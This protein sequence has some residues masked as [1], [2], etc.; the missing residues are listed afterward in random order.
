[1]CLVPAKFRQIIEITPNQSEY[2]LNN[3][4][5]IQGAPLFVKQ[6]FAL[7]FLGDLFMPNLRA[8]GTLNNIIQRC[9]AICFGYYTFL[10]K[11]YRICF[12][13]SLI[14]WC[15]VM[16]LLLYVLKFSSDRYPN[17]KRRIMKKRLHPILTDNSFL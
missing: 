10:S 9:M 13:R 6:Y 11:L 8:P 7:L 12:S 3:R 2:S 15:L 16:I 1:M 17:Q 4:F 5:R 14:Y